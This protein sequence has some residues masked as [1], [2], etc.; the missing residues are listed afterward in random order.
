[1]HTQ[2]KL[3]ISAYIVWIFLL[4]GYWENFSKLLGEICLN[5]IFYNKLEI[6]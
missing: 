2:G 3:E 4:K 5:Q 6:N 1:M